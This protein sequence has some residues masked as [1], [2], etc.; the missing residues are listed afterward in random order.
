MAGTCEVLV[1]VSDTSDMSHER[2]GT[3]LELDSN[4]VLELPVDIVLHNART[5]GK[6][7]KSSV[8]SSLSE[9]E[10][11]ENMMITIANSEHM[12]C[13]KRA[14]TVVPEMLHIRNKNCEST[15]TCDPIML[16]A[17]QIRLSER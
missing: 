8:F 14:R 3:K 6:N 5:T 7:G 9:L 13:L 12:R 4:G 11:I 15:S 10:Q 17:F 1:A 2:C 16:V